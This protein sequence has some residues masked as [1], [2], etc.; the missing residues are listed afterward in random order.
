MTAVI[1]VV[2][3]GSASRPCRKRAGASKKT[4]C[5]WGEFILLDR[6]VRGEGILLKTLLFLAGSVRRGWNAKY[7]IVATIRCT[8]HTVNHRKLHLPHGAPTT[9]CA[10]H[11]VYL[12]HSGLTTWWHTAPTT[13]W[14]EPGPS[15]ITQ[16][17]TT[18]CTYHTVH[19]PHSALTTQCT[20]LGPSPATCCTYHTVHMQLDIL[21]SASRTLA[22]FNMSS[23]EPGLVEYIFS[24]AMVYFAAWYELFEALDLW[25]L[26]KL[27]LNVGLLESLEEISKGKLIQ[28]RREKGNLNMGWSRDYRDISQ[29]YWGAFHS[30]RK[31]GLNFR[32]LPEAD[33]TAFS[34]ISKKSANSR[35]IPKF[36][37]TFPLKFSFHLS[38]SQ[39]F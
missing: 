5:K 33:G 16:W 27:A 23:Q 38:C 22:E 14:T 4:L 20:D 24:G 8:C 18:H 10:H 37:E 36:S 26:K 39:N 31:S 35:G 30:N 15:P 2:T 34:K 32:Q 12:Q 6:R 11:M 28:K 21:N 19:L 29:L 9:Q 1:H 13:Q 7:H 17:T 3:R 25:G